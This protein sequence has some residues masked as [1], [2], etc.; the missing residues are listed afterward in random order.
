[1]KDW[2]SV[3]LV[4]INLGHD[5]EEIEK[6]LWNITYSRATKRKSF[7][8]VNIQLGKQFSLNINGHFSVYTCSYLSMGDKKNL[9]EQ[10][11]AFDYGAG[12]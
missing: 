7:K 1:M 6:N 9:C 12:R 4:Y 10:S 8:S 11:A 5:K 3:H 2:T